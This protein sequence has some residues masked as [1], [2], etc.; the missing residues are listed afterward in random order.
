MKRDQLMVPVTIYMK[1]K[2]ADKLLAEGKQEEAK[3]Y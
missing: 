3:M 1:V 2:E